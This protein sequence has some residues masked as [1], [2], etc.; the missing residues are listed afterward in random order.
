MKT[1]ILASMLAHTAV[2][3]TVVAVHMAAAGP[4]AGSQVPDTGR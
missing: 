4:A 2:S 1:L 3:G